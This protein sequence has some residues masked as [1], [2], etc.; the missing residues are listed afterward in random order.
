MFNNTAPFSKILFIFTL[1]DHDLEFPKKKKH[2]LVLLSESSDDDINSENENDLNTE[3]KSI[4]NSLSPLFN[5]SE[6][7]VSTQQLMGFCSG[8]FQSQKLDAKV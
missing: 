1:L 6:A 5:D 8:Q 2:R 7:I 3:N 4:P